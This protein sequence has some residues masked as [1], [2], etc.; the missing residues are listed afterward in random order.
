MQLGYIGYLNSIVLSSIGFYSPGLQYS[1]GEDGTL[2]PACYIPK[3]CWLTI[4]SIGP[5]YTHKTGGLCMSFDRIAQLF[6]WATNQTRK[7]KISGKPFF[8][9]QLLP[10]G[11]L[12]ILYNIQQ[13]GCDG[14]SFYFQTQKGHQER[15]VWHHPSTRRKPNKQKRIQHCGYYDNMLYSLIQSKTKDDTRR[16]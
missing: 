16:Q 3:M 8:A 5:V 10:R 2:M 15:H 13:I 1:T 6:P 12:H 7:K 14:S 11:V 9:I 4:Y